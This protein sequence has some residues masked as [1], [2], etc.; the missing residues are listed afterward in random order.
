LLE[1]LAMENETARDDGRKL[2]EKVGE[3]EAERDRQRLAAQIGRAT[4]TTVPT[5]VL[6]V[7]ACTIV[8][9]IGWDTPANLIANLT[10]LL[11]VLLTLLAGAYGML[12]RRDLLAAPAARI[13][14]W[15]QMSVE[16]VVDQ[17]AKF[18]F[19]DRG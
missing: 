14:S 17:A 5:I 13:R 3:L 9:T 2:Q 6:I 8:V 7:A 12:G 11:S 18:R 16:P 15:M 1:H 4:A 19:R 10:V